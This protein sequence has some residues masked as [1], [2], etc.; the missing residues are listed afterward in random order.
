MDSSV[1]NENVGVSFSYSSPQNYSYKLTQESLV[2]SAG[3]FG[4]IIGFIY[5]YGVKVGK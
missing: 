4:Q 2:E 1:K 3:Q 5:N